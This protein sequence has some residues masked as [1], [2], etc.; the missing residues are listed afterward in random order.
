MKR[1]ARRHLGMKQPAL[2]RETGGAID[3]S[4]SPSPPRTCTRLRRPR[5]GLVRALPE[6]LG[7]DDDGRIRRA[8][9]WASCL[10]HAPG[11]SP[12]AGAPCALVVDTVRPRERLATDVRSVWL[13][14]V[15]GSS[16]AHACQIRPDTPATTTY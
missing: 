13:A 10:G 4:R 6:L 5:E 16:G 1:S 2:E 14:D 12:S 11:C 3:R 7:R 8:R 15:P 9:I